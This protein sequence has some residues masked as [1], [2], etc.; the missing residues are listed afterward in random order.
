MS[1]ISHEVDP[2]LRD[3]L[4]DFFATEVTPEVIDAAERSGTY[5]A[6]V[7]KKAESLDL[8][9]IG[10]DEERGGAGGSLADLVALVGEASRR[11]TPAPF[12]EHHLA[13]WLLAHSDLGQ[14]EGPLTVAGL[15][16]DPVVVDAG[17]L[18]ATLPDV[19]WAS[20]ATAIV[21]L[22][23]DLSGADVVAVLR[24]QDAILESYTDIDG[25]P[26]ASVVATDA[27][28]QVAPLELS[29]EAVLRRAALLRSAVLAGL[30]RAMF[31]LTKTYVAERH[32]FGKPVGSF[33][34][35]QLHT[36]TLAQNSAMS[37]VCVDRATGALAIGGGEFE[38]LATTAVTAQNAVQ[39]A[40]SAH[41]AHGAIGM[42]R[43]YPLQFLTRRVQSWR[44]RWQSQAEVEDAVASW[45]LAAPALSGLIARHREEGVVA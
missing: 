15:S 33:Q 5:A 6:D 9:S 31:E 28:V 27:A 13:A 17:H 14:I 19:T 36:V 2:D 35:V 4:E 41:Q 12:V 26:V 24:P 30:T 1:A 40:R 18:T 23:R 43:E 3:M 45:A 8:P 32:Q 42:T 22:A 44:Q 37:Q 39:S 11:A 21:L 34:S 25:T 29:R 16:G 20:D 10:I 7:W 38:V